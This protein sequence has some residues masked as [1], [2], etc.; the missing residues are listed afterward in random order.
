MGSEH[1]YLEEMERKLL[2]LLGKGM[3]KVSPIPRIVSTNLNSVSLKFKVLEGRCPLEARVNLFRG[4]QLQFSL[5][6]IFRERMFQNN[7]TEFSKQEKK[8]SWVKLIR[9]IG[10][11]EKTHKYMRYRK[12][13]TQN[14]S[15]NMLEA[16]LLFKL[17]IQ[18]V[19]DFVLL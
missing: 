8:M 5:Q 10:I 16:L 15:G 17:K 12:Y 18:S 9:N 11:Q 1:S 2:W 19:A 13:Q 3:E 7:Q 6:R 14:S 4:T